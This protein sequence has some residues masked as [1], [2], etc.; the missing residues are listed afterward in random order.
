[1]A[2]VAAA[3]A[4]GIWWMLRARR[5]FKVLVETDGVV[6]VVGEIPGTHHKRVTGFVDTLNLDEG[7]WI[8]A[9]ADKRSGVAFRFS[10]GFDPQKAAT[11]RDHF[12][13]LTRSGGS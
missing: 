13:Y 5:V 1:M 9:V 10:K 7:S 8:L 12:R 6:R 4:L 11:V 3:V 2:A